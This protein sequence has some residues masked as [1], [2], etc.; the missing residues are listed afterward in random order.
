MNFIEVEGPEGGALPAVG[1][2]EIGSSMVPGPVP[3]HAICADVNSVFTV[4]RQCERRLDTKSVD[5]MCGVCG[6]LNAY[7][8]RR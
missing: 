1:L 3:A 4:R 2:E 7:I 6:G 8:G 5:S